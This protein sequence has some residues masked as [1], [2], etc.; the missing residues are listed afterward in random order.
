MALFAFYKYFFHHAVLNYC[1]FHC[2]LMLLK[3]LFSVLI[4]RLCHLYIFNRTYQFC[5]LCT[6]W[7]MIRLF[8]SLPVHIRS[9]VLRLLYGSIRIFVNTAFTSLSL[10]SNSISPSMNSISSFF[11]NLICKSPSEIKRQEQISNTK[12]NI[13][14]ES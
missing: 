3:S 14:F 9:Q 11:V 13:R 8:R 12:L 2:P 5:F 7:F 6:L 4:F 10:L 1:F